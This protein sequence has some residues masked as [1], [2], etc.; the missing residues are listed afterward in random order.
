MHTTTPPNVL[1]WIPTCRLIHQS[2]GAG[3]APAKGQWKEARE[4]GGALWAAEPP[5]A[6]SGPGHQRSAPPLSL[7]A[8]PTGLTG[9]RKGGR[10]GSEWLRGGASAASE[11]P[12]AT[13]RPGQARPGGHPWPQVEAREDAPKHTHLLFRGS[14]T[15]SP[16]TGRI[17]VGSRCC[18]GGRAL[19]G[20]SGNGVQAFTKAPDPV[21]AAPH[22]CPQPLPWERGL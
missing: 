19:R 6:T 20:A 1:R 7:G 4:E 22:C 9:S 3:P 21:P 13:G 12:L 17:C 15:C 8:A 10:M 14:S 2:T 5:L 11:K 18:V 16:P